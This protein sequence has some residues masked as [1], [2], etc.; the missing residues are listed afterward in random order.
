MRHLK[1]AHAGG[2]SIATAVM[3]A[4]R[5]Q[6][7]LRTKMNGV[8]QTLGGHYQQGCQEILITAGSK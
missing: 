8:A 2:I 6:E 3:G 7:E 4:D 5:R 1:R